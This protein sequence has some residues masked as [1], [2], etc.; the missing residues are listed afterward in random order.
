MDIRMRLILA[1]ATWC[2]DIEPFD[3]REMLT[4]RRLPAGFIVK[5]DGQRTIAWCNRC[6]FRNKR[7]MKEIG[8]E[9]G[10]RMAD[11]WP[12]RDGINWRQKRSPGAKRDLL[13]RP[14]LSPAKYPNK[15]RL[16]PRC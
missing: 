10:G 16:V 9:R 5:D 13:Q 11:T 1:M 4:T 15:T 12:V 2:Y 3:R 14:C 8:G 7:Q 6:G